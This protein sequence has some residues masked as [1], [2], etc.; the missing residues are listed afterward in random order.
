M[1]PREHRI[2]IVEDE[3]L[4][5]ADLQG[6]LEKAGYKVP[7]VAGT[8]GEALEVIREKSPDLILMDIRL[9]G[10][11]DGIQV[12]EQVRRE[13]DIPVVYLTA[14]EDRKTL[15]RASKTQAFGYIKKPI[16]SAS[17]EGSIEMAIS[18][19]RHERYLREQRDWFSAS[20]AAVADAVLVTDGLGRV[21]YINPIAEELTGCKVEDALGKPSTELLRLRYPSGRLVDDLAPL[22]MLQG[23]PVSIPGD[24]WL[25]GQGKRYAIEG[26]LAPRW[27]EGRPDGVVVTFKDVTLRRFEQ[28]QSRQDS[29]HEALSRLADGIAGHLDLELSVVAEESTRLLNSLPVDSAIRATAETIESAALDAFA[30]TCRLRAFGQERELKPHVVRVN[31]VLRDLQSTWTGALPGL[32][33]QLD[34][35]PRPVHA[36]AHELTRVL[37]MLLQHAHHWMEAASGIRVAA[38]GAEL[39]GLPEWVQIRITYT[40]TGEDAAA[41]ERAFDP[42][43]DGNW[44]GLPFAYGITKRMGGLMRARMEPD[45]TAVFEVYLPSVEVAAAGVPIESE[46]APVLLVI[47]PNSEV[48]RLL[49]AHFEQHG[50]SV[51]EVSNCEEALLLAESYERPIRLAIANPAMEDK[52]RAELAARLVDLKPGI[53]VRLIENYREECPGAEP[54]GGETA[55]RYM[56]KWELLEWA[57]DA[58][59]SVAWLSTAN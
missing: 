19:H 13:F 33:V 53:C 20:F 1:E 11:I 29:K 46:K 31:E 58:L 15:E 30:V 41:L 59:G 56:T 6:R 42:S 25:E 38:S 10:N 27:Q 44:E 51:L 23:A 54:L 2:V 36:D 32:N 21:C 24:V 3:G 57:H 40:T 34:P 5:A 39:D 52:R 26:S 14:Y 45:K 48:R 7:A 22:V 17:L 18:K 9:K 4:I 35:N 12:A 16:A 49:H 50:Y 37:D 43:W 47:E 55:W 8:G 28:E